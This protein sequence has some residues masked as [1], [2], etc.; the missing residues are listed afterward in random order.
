MIAAYAVS[1]VY[2]ACGVACDP[3]QSQRSLIH[4]VLFY[5]PEL[6]NVIQA[7][8]S[9][10]LLLLSLWLITATRLRARSIAVEMQRTCEEVFGVRKQMVGGGDA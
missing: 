9:P 6:D 2:D 8:G 10:L 3:C 5:T 4:T 7:L 1:G